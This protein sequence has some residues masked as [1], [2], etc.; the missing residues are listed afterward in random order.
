MSYP[1]GFL[2]KQ[3]QNVEIKNAHFL[4][5]RSMGAADFEV[6]LLN[7]SYYVFN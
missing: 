7:Q 1:N 4:S 5:F 2:V 6:Q 3:K